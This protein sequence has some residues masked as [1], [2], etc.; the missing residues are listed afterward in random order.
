LALGR[1]QFCLDYLSQPGAFARLYPKLLEGYLLDALEQIDRGPA[2]RKQLRAF[3]GAVAGAPQR[4]SASAGL[5]EDLRLAGS[6][7]VA[8]G[9]AV[10]EELL[11]L[12]AFNSEESDARTRVVRPSRRG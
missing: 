11:Q 3:T 10:E 2:T 5:G 9:L 1:D 7:I 8:S 6:G 12:S 4:R